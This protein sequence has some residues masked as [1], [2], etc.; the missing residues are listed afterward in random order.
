MP[1]ALGLLWRRL[2]GGEQSP[3]RTAL[4]V[5]LG[6]FVGS[7][8]IYG[9]H[10]PICLLACVPLRLD[11]VLAYVAANISNPLVAPFLLLLQIQTGALLLSGRPLPLNVDA[12]RELGAGAFLA[13]AALG[14]AVVASALAALGFAVSLGLARRLPGKAPLS[15][16]EGAID[17]TI[18][19]YRRAAIADRSYVSAKLATDPV[20]GEL[21]K[22]AGPFG[23]VLDAGAGRGQFGLLLLEL[24]GVELL[25]GFDWDERKLSVARLAAGEAACFERADLCT[26]VFPPADTILLIDVLHYLPA[27]DQDAVLVRAARALSPGGRL[28]LR[29]CDRRPGFRSFLTRT[30]ERIGTRAGYNRGAVLEFRPVR[31]LIGVLEAEG[32][33]CATPGVSTGALSNVLV[34]ASRPIAPPVGPEPTAP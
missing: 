34:V 31:E 25:T 4:S 33:T 26:A 32:L 18:A 3:R 14:S 8:P 29:E 19:R 27:A 24:G 2:R 30:F 21:L 7:L 1:N 5:A 16:K 9:L 13:Q 10:F 12:V 6:L 28:L 11:F 15:A 23:R 22:L 20:A 17:R